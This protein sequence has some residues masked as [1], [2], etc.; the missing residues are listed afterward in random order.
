MGFY[1]Q[2]RLSKIIYADS[3]YVNVG[4]RGELYHEETRPN[5]NGTV[6]EAHHP[7]QGQNA[8]QGRLHHRR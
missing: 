4:F 5:E 8:R 2:I 3:V 6:D 1:L 7:H